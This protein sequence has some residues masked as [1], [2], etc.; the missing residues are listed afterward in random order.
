MVVVI[1]FDAKVK[2]MDGRKSRRWRRKRKK[3]VR[4]CGSR[5]RIQQTKEG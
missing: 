2:E 5:E 3:R 1:V 4:S